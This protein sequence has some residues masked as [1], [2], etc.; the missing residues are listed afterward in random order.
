MLKKPFLH[1]SLLPLTAL[2]GLTTFAL[3]ALAYFPLSQ[4]ARTQ[5][6]SSSMLIAGLKFKVPNVGSSGNREAGASRG[7][8]PAV[9]QQSMSKQRLAALVPSN[10]LAL[11]QSANPT[12][13]FYL[14]EGSA[15]KAEF[16]LID[17]EDEWLYDTEIDLPDKV[18][19]VSFKLPKDGLQ[20]V[21]LSVGEEYRWYVRLRCSI[22]ADRSGSSVVGGTIKRVQLSN[23]LVD[24]KDSEY[25]AAYAEAGLW[26]DTLASLADLLDRAPEDPNLNEAALKRDWRGL[27]L[28]HLFVDPR[29]QEQEKQRREIADADLVGSATVAEI[30]E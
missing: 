8:C 4:I 14:T 20:P 17:Q 27:L 22:S 29:T 11:T 30:I 1:L 21:S 9:G 6:S 12:F 16:I 19:V 23:S 3:P 13:F 2:A 18:G 26:Q 15:T 7:Q 25:P 28:A 5:G 10:L 24:L